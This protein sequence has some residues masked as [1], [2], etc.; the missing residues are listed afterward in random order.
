MPNWIALGQTVWPYVG[1]VP[2]FTMHMRATTQGAVGH[3]GLRSQHIRICKGE[4]AL[5]ETTKM[6]ETLTGGGDPQI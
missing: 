5:A 1:L 3:G 2:K 4:G 6:L